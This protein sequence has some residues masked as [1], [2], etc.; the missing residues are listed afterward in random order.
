MNKKLQ[1]INKF[2]R[3]IHMGTQ[4]FRVYK[5]KTTDVKLLNLF[6]EALKVF[7]KHENI[8]TAL[9]LDLEIDPTDELSIG[10][11]F[12]IMMER[13]KKPCCDFAVGIYA[14][15][16]LNM[17]LIGGLEFIYEHR[18]FSLKHKLI[19]NEVID[20]YVILIKKHLEKLQEFCNQ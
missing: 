19:L 2:L 1:E 7:K 3:S 20:D 9:L 5:E 14:L 18:D 13:M 11:D 4:T 15:K 10:N 6:D 16:A 17:G 8:L 12:V